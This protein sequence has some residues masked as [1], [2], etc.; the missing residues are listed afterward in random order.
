MSTQL[1]FILLLLSFYLSLNILLIRDS[2]T[3]YLYYPPKGDINIIGEVVS[4]EMPKPTFYPM[5]RQK[6]PSD[7]YSS[8]K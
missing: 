7:K 3:L 2:A 5:K 6:M 4:G 8:D 1:L